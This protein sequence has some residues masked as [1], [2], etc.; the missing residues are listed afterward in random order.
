M[1][2]LRDRAGA[3]EPEDL[4]RLFLDRASAGDVDGVVALHEPDAVLASPPGGLSIGTAAIRCRCRGS[5]P[6]WTALRTYSP[7]LAGRKQPTGLCNAGR[8][9][10]RPS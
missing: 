8:F 3:A 9:F 6:R 10:I 5:P 2:D 1:S 4:A 7:I